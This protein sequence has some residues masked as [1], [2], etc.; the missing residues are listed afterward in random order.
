[1]I[2]NIYESNLRFE[3]IQIPVNNITFRIHT[4][5][6][7]TGL[8]NISGAFDD[9][10]GFTEI[11]LLV[12]F[13]NKK[14]NLSLGDLNILDFF[15]NTLGFSYLSLKL[16]N[17]ETPEFYENMYTSEALEIVL[18]K[19]INT[20][21]DMPSQNGFPHEFNF[22]GKNLNTLQN[23]EGKNWF[24]YSNNRNLFNKSQVL[25]K[26]LE[27]INTN[28]CYILFHGTSW[29]GGDIYNEWNRNKSKIKCN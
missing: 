8:K 13:L 4:I 6:C 15:L 10:D 9:S 23:Y 5:E 22:S 12:S 29:E 25:E 24:P 21:N 18:N 27:N 20:A 28:D 26:L 2:Q 11:E 1:M 16:I 14:Y 7:I 3:P 17:A 19:L